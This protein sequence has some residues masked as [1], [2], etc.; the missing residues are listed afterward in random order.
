MLFS[1]NV[2]KSVSLSD[3]GPWLPAMM[4]Y[5]GSIYCGSKALSHFPVP[6]FLLSHGASDVILIMCDRYL[7]SGAIH[8][9]L[10]LKI[11]SIFFALWSV[12]FD[13][14]ISDLIWIILNS[15]FSGAYRTASFWYTTPQWPYSGLNVIQR[16]YL[17]NLLGLV[18]LF[19][20]GFFLGHHYQVQTY[21][22]YLG[23]IRFYIGC[24]CS[25]VLSWAVNFTWGKI[26]VK[27]TPANVHM[28]QLAG[29]IVT[30]LISFHLFPIGH[31]MVLW[32]AIFLGFFGDICY[33]LGSMLEPVI[34]Q[35]HDIS[36]VLIGS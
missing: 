31:T 22:Q 26:N 2:L 32:L 24:V 1:G 25:G 4:F 23:E 6:V 11:S 21:F 17:N 8:F 7:P 29:K 10:P 3:I 27:N 33:I 28:V 12:H 35:G 30:V 9:S 16:Q 34:D 36:D 19:P 5:V 20:L 15:V 18:T 14:S 13:I